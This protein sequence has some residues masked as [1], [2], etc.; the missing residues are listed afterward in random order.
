M[1]AVPMLAAVMVPVKMLY[2]ERVVGDDVMR[3]DDDDDEDDDEDE[4][5]G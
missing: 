2:V 3:N 4:D 1:V 5:S